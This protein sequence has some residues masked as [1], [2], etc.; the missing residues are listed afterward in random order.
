MAN[1]ELGLHVLSGSRV[2][3][4]MAYSGFFLHSERRGRIAM[5]RQYFCQDHAVRSVVS[6]QDF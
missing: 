6:S 2:F 5:L 3:R 1:R 4:E